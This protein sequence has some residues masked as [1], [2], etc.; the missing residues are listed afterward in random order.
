[1]NQE[2]AIAEVEERARS[3]EPN[4]GSHLRAAKMLSEKFGIESA[5]VRV[6]ILAK[7]L[8]L[9]P[10]TIY[11]QLKAGRFCMPFRRVNTIPLVKVED[12]I[13]WYCDPGAEPALAP[14]LAVAALPEV[15]VSVAPVRSEPVVLCPESERA[16]RTKK[17][18]GEVLSKMA[19]PSHGA[20][21]SVPKRD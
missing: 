10:S 21:S 8:G 13:N 1:M 12:L 5:F 17:L 18:V 6:E 3:S 16:A 15:A 9:A 20:R 7:V 2:I 19:K 11:T 14:V 4:D